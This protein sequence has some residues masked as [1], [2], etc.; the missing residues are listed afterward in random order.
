M[1]G[2]NFQKIFIHIIVVFFVFMAIHCSEDLMHQSCT[3][4]ME[5]YQTENRNTNAKVPPGGYNLQLKVR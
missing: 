1:V 4:Y 5:L 3:A 2:Q